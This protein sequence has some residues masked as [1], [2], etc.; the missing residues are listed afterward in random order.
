MISDNFKHVENWVF[1]LDN[2][3]YPPKV[4]LFDEIELKMTEWISNKLKIST[5]EADQ[6][7]KRYWKAYGTSLAGLMRE[8]QIKPYEYLSYVHDISFQNLVKD[9]KLH[10]RIN[11]LPGRKIVYTNGTA[12]YAKN[13]LGALGLSDLFESIYGVEDADFYPKPERKAYEIIFKKDGLDPLKSAMFEDEYRNLN[14]P[15]QM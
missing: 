8:Y 10:A 4:R 15:K 5:Q 9:P 14:I 7:R 11:S 1:D 3:L 6:L 2:T 12:E 13:V